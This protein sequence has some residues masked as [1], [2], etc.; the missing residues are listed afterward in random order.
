[1]GENDSPEEIEAESRWVM[2]HLGPDVPLHF[3]AFH[4]DWKMME[5]P[6]TPPATLKMARRIALEAGLRFVYT[7]HNPHCPGPNPHFRPHR[8]RLVRSHGVESLRRRPLRRL[9]R[10]LR[11]RVRRRARDMG[12]APPVRQDPRAPRGAIQGVI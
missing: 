11:R 1:P 2:E 10:G 4:P 6:A 9:R 12:P 7:A 5:T 8:P 3:T